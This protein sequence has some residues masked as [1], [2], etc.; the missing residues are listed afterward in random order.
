MRVT[1]PPAA[2]NQRALRRRH[3]PSAVDLMNA[4]QGLLFAA[5][6]FLA[7]AD[8]LVQTFIR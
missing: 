6:A 2:D 8:R 4:A 1:R 5:A 7:T 3:S